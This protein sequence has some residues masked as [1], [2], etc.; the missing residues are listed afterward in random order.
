M[1]KH[2]ARLGIEARD[3]QRLNMKENEIE[4]WEDS[5]RTN[6]NKYEYEWWY[7][8]SKL[9]DGSSL[10]IDFFPTSLLNHKGRVKPNGMIRYTKPDG[11][12]INDEFR[13]PKEMATFGK[14]HCSVRIGENYIEGDLQNY[15]IKYKT[16]KIEAEVELIGRVPSWRPATGHIFFDEEKYFA[17]FPSVPS[18]SV[19]ATI[20]YDGKTE[21]L[22]G[23]GYHDHNWGNAPMF[24]L[25]H[26]WYWGRA[27]IGDYDVIS[28]YITCQKK[29]GYKHVMV[30]MLAKDGK[31]ISEN[32]ANPDYFQ[33]EPEYDPVV[34]K[35]FH[36]KITYHYYASDAEYRITYQMKEH[37]EHFNLKDAMNRKLVDF[38]LMVNR[39]DPSY[40]RF[41][42]DITLEKIVDGEIVEKIT[43]PGMWE[44]MYFDKDKDV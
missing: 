44:L 19:K 12:V 20:K 16:D 1:A 37:L 25:L 21:V 38:L 27:K 6:C 34:R 15:K 9:F 18:G 31:I 39:L 35:H 8:D 10:V 3:Y 29:Y 36:K 13:L 43:A 22:E 30:F 33:T 7:F 23:Y 2:E 32:L 4:K 41:G 14:E 40:S 42:G 28:S 24:Y 5:H 17:W 26:H 11:T